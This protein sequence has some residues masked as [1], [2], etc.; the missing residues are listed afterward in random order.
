MRS[1]EQGI[2]SMQLTCQ[3]HK[4][5]VRDYRQ[6]EYKEATIRLLKQKEEKS[7]S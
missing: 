1:T 6:H 4:N 2:V 5:Y 3:V 7:F